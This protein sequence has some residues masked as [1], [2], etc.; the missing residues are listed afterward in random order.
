MNGL[1]DDL[2]ID[3]FFFKKHISKS[4]LYVSNGIVKIE[5][6]E[7]DEVAFYEFFKNYDF[8]K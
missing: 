7:C 5:K 1:E 8:E 2:S 4:G 3:E 6:E